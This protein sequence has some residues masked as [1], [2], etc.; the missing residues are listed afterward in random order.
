[1][2]RRYVEKSGLETGTSRIRCRIDDLTLRYEYLTRMIKDQGV[3]VQKRQ[4]AV[5][6]TLLAPFL[7]AKAANN[8]KSLGRIF[9]D[10]DTRR[11]VRR[12]ESRDF[13]NSRLDAA[14]SCVV[15]SE[16]YICLAAVHCRPWP[17]HS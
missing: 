11:W 17:L 1:M 3:K 7:A 2:E 16:I 13:F 14:V 15:V 5:I 9:K 8:M 6:L 12:L 10:L 4:E